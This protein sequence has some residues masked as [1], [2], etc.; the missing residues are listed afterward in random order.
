MKN[1]RLHRSSGGASLVELMIGT[2]MFSIVATVMLSI[3][4]LNTRELS[5]FYNKQDVI[6]QATD[7]IAKIGMLTRT[8]RGFGDNYGIIQPDATPLFDFTKLLSGDQ[9]A[10]QSGINVTAT[11][12]NLLNGSAFLI[13]PTFP[14]P[15]DP[16]YGTGALPASVYGGQWPM[17]A[18]AQVNGAPALPGRYTLGQDTLIVQVPVFIGSN[19][20][21]GAPGVGLDPSQGGVAP[22]IWPAT[23][24]GQPPGASGVMQAVDT[25]VFKVSPNPQ[26]PGT[27]M[28]QQAAFPACPQGGANPLGGVYNGHPTNVR[29][30]LVA[31]QTLVTG[32]VGPLD[33]QG[34][35]SIFNYVEK[36]NNT[37]T[38]TP[39]DAAH[40]LTDY[41]G[42]IVNMEVL[43]TQSG[44]KASVAAFKTE[45]F[46]RNNSQITLMGPPNG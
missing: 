22:F 20:N 9:N 25:Y 32:I 26:Q 11:T 14:S 39:P 8:A 30:G 44:R 27:W 46:L 29:M 15:G 10:K 40:V 34:N 28:L 37:A 2:L 41:N 3:Y 35:I 45:F 12:T 33:N 1:Q 5:G 43:K 38:V 13:S 31:P 36:V 19:P 24:N 7:A 6:T 4:S 16:Y 21:P 23:W 42:V 18:S 17:L